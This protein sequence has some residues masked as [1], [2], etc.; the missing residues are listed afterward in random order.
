MRQMQKNAKHLDE[1]AQ[2]ALA[3]G[4]LLA[5]PDEDPARDD[6]CARLL[7]NVGHRLPM[8]DL[9]ATTVPL[10]IINTDGLPD[11]QLGT[12]AGSYCSSSARVQDSDNRGKQTF[13]ET[14]RVIIG[15]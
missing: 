13:A 2:F 7:C 12:G 3:L 15:L 4:N 6:G 1:Q 8:R 9:H 14:D 5:R 10:L 11:A